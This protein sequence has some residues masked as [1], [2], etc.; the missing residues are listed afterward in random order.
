MRHG[1]RGIIRLTTAPH[2]CKLNVIEEKLIED[3]MNERSARGE[4]IDRKPVQ[5]VVRQGTL[6]TRGRRID[7]C[8]SSL[9][10]LM[11]HL[12]LTPRAAHVRRRHEADPPAEATL[13]SAVDD[14]LADPCSTPAI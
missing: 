12:G 14:I 1:D 6:E 4:K 8:L 10:C 9:G 3:A 7:M 11:H 2:N 13:L 5:I